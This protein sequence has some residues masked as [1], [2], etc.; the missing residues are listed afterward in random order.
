MIQSHCFNS[1]WIDSVSK[2]LKYNDKNLIE[3]VIRALSLLEML[4]EAECPMVFK[5]G[6]SLMLILN[7]TANRLSIDI[8]VICP[9]GTDIEQYL[10]AYKQH[11][12]TNKELIER[13]SRGNDV[14]KS[15]SKFFYQIA[16]T[17][18]NDSPAYILLD[19]LYESIHYHQTEEVAIQSPFIQLDGEPLMVTVPSA[20]DILGDKLT[21]FAPNTTGIPY[22]KVNKRGESKDCALEICKQLFDI[23]RL[24]EKVDEVS[25][26]SESFKKIAEVELSYRGLSNDL[27]VVYEDIR[28]TALCISTR[29]IVGNGNFAQLQQGVSK[30]KSFMYKQKYIIDNAIVDAARAAYL[31][32]LIEKGV[33]EI[34]KYHSAQDVMALQIAD[35][36]TNKL[37]KLR[38]RLPEAFFYWAKT[39]ELLKH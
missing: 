10:T 5:G 33:N 12:F 25:V 31:A 22:F 27:S 6:T 15:H 17:D 39:S 38:G 19:V 23:G 28:Q 29:G 20:P 18:G 36:L 30:L 2:Q 7:D 8:D 16:Y 35:T 13:K 32:T 34:E 24:F 21:A 9:P 14:P 1:A 4:V 11:G 26:T 37:N 3:K